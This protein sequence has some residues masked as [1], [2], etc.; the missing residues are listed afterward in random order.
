MAESKSKW[1]EK[2]SL[3]LLKQWELTP[4]VIEEYLFQSCGSKMSEQQKIMFIGLSMAYWL[5]PLKRQIYPVPFYNSETQKMDMQPVIAYTVAIAK[6]QESKQLDGYNVEVHRDPEDN[7]KI[8]GATITIHRKDWSHPFEHTVIYDEVVGKKKDGNPTSIWASRP[9]F[10]IRKVAIGQWMRLCFPDELQW[11]YV[12]EEMQ[13]GVQVVDVSDDKKPS[14]VDLSKVQAGVAPKETK[15]TT[16]QV[17]A[18]VT[19][20]IPDTTDTED[21][22]GTAEWE[23][24]P[25][26]DA[27][28]DEVLNPTDTPAVVTPAA[29]TEPATTPAA[30]KKPK[31]WDITLPQQTKIRALWLKKFPDDKKWDI[32]V[33]YLE[34]YFQVNNKAYLSKWQAD[35]M[36]ENL[37]QYNAK[38]ILQ[39]IW[40]LPPDERF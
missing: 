7:K 27:E 10:M 5:N 3:K 33:K 13:T 20:D 40:L 22:A 14:T 6:A 37:E 15:P 19:H 16:E 8:T 21:P 1:Q 25:T 26:G 31:K 2:T 23:Y 18:T 11:L 29:P 35:D 34:Y 28:L 9:D 38:E 39:D 4:E 36:I 30:T 32:A 24:V 12:E 17:I